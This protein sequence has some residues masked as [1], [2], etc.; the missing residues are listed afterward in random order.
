MQEILIDT[1]VEEFRVNGAEVLRFNPGDPNLYHR[2]FAA[3]QTM[4][5]YDEELN[6]QAAALEGQ[7]GSAESRAAAVLA[8]LGEYDGKIKRLLGEIFGPENDFDAVLAGVN[9]AG[10][11][12]N[13]KRVVQNLLEALTPILREGA[14]KSLRA[15]ADAA[16][17]QAKAARSERRGAPV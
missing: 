17:A 5:E 9:L 14:E 6:R 7:P 15:T 11:G 10:V 1:G 3:R 13:G 4:A 8:L 16:V 2:F 12:A